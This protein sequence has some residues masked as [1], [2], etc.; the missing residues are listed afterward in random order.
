MI[1][2]D[3]NHAAIMQVRSIDQH[4]SPTGRRTFLRMPV[5]HCRILANHKHLQHL[6]DRYIK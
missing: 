3:L 6:S 5:V 2:L 4:S 1:Q